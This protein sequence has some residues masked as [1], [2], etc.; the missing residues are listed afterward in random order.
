MND[1]VRMR[2][3]ERVCGFTQHASRFAEPH[4]AVPVQLLRETFTPD[5]PH[6]H[7]HEPLGLFDRINRNDMRMGEGRCHLR[8]AQETRAHVAPEG[9]LRWERLDGDRALESYVRSCIDNRHAT[10]PEFVVDDVPA[11]RGLDQAIPK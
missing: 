9:E 3:H 5:K 8:F 7:E 11:A 1:T 10:A 6:D 2:V 4:S